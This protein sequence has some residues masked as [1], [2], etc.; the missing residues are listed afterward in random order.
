MKKLIIAALAVYGGVKLG[1][2]L[3]KR[4]RKPIIEWVGKKAKE[5][6]D[7]IIDD[8]LAEEVEMSESPY[9]R[10]V[11]KDKRTFPTQGVINYEKHEVLIKGLNVDEANDILKRLRE[12]LKEYKRVTTLDL[13]KVSLVDFP[14]SSF[15]FGWDCFDE[16]SIMTFDDGRCTLILPNMERFV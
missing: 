1:E 4:Y 5:A 8:I 14:S 3:L 10:E 9:I 6:A 16:A 7:R 11:K 15:G 13:Y 12:V 2:K